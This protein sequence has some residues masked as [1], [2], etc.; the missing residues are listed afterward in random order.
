MIGHFNNSVEAALE[1]FSKFIWSQLRIKKAG[2][3]VHQLYQ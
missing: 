3:N 1:F 2:E